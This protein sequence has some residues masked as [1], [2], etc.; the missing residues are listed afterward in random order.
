MKPQTHNLRR[1]C[2]GTKTH[3]FSRYENFPIG[4]DGE[5]E[6]VA[7]ASCCLEGIELRLTDVAGNQ[8]EMYAQYDGYGTPMS[9]GLKWGLI[10]GGIALAVIIIVVIVVCCCKKSGGYGGVSTNA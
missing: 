4:T 9:K 2:F 3:L 5:Y 10:G 6:I 7:G 8:A 1:F